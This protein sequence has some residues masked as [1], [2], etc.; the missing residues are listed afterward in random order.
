MVHIKLKVTHVLENKQKVYLII[1]NTKAGQ[2]TLYDMVSIQIF[3]K[4]KK[5]RLNC[6]PH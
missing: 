3:D 1:L 4:L 2:T 5:S 6:S